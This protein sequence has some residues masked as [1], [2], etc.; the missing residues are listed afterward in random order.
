MAAHDKNQKFKDP[1]KAQ[2][3]IDDYFDNTDFPTY[4]GMIRHLGFKSRQSWLNYRNSDNRELAEVFELG[5]LRIEEIYEIRLNNAKSP[6]AAI[7]ALKNMG[8]KDKDV[9]EL[10]TQKNPIHMAVT[11]MTIK[12]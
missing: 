7:F 12:A 9:D 4:T 5:T 6:I 1:E 10:G 8:W 2:I 3:L 11:G